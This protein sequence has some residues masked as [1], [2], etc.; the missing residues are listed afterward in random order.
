MKAPREHLEDSRETL[1]LELA[2]DLVIN[3]RSLR[4]LI[5]GVAIALGEVLGY[6]EHLIKISL[7]EQDDCLFL[8]GRDLW[9][10]EAV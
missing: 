5:F 7:E 2:Q 1:G 8:L 6:L 4:L 9:G 10:K 3:I